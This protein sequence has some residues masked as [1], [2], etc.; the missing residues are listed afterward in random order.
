MSKFP[1]G[2]IIE[3]LR[4]VV[5]FDALSE[6]ELDQVAT[7]MEIAYYYR[8]AIIYK[9]GAPPPSIMS[10]KLCVVFWQFNFWQSHI[11]LRGFNQTL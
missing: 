4:S 10:H 6:E 3:F 9:Q 7:K 5:P 11:P 8:G 1:L 2:R